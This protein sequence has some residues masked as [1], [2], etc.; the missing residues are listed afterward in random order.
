VTFHI[1]AFS[2]VVQRYFDKRIC[3]GLENNN[4]EYT[5][6]MFLPLEKWEEPNP[7]RAG[8]GLALKTPFMYI[9]ATIGW[10]FSL[11]WPLK[12]PP[13]GL[14]HAQL[15]APGCVQN[16][17]PR[18]LLDSSESQFLL[19]F[20]VSSHGS[21]NDTIDISGDDEFFNFLHGGDEE[22][23]SNDLATIRVHD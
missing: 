1:C 23:G 19:L 4:G 18:K 6:P 12:G 2:D 10:S 22:M 11:P 8:L 17:T 14:H 7:L 3:Q 15:P 5:N 21:T 13:P 20:S 9:F 16:A